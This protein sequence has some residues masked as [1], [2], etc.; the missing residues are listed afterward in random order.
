MDHAAK[1]FSEGQ[2][3]GYATRNVEVVAS[4]CQAISG[5]VSVLRDAAVAWASHHSDAASVL[6]DL[7][8]KLET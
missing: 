7:E 1:L 4:I 5:A 2:T 8:R 3:A 6:A